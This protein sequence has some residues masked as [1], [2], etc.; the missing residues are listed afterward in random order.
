MAL[1]PEDVQAIGQL[2][3]SRMAQ[4]SEA[5]AKQLRDQD[6]R[7]R[8]FWSWVIWITVI[9]T[10]AS[11][12]WSYYWLK[13]K[14][15][16]LLASTASLER[17]L[18]QSRTDLAEARGEYASQL[19][20]DKQ[21]QKERAEAVSTSGYKSDQNQAQF[22]AGMLAKT[23]ALLNRSNEARSRAERKAKSGDTEPDDQSVNDLDQTI[24]QA[25]GLLM[26]LMLHETDPEH[27]GSAEKMAQGEHP[28]ATPI[29]QPPAAGQAKPPAAPS[30]QPA[31]APSPAQPATAS[32]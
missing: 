30:A 26:Q 31:R 23:F 4:H 27:Q 16:G 7:R 18:S 32:K 21:M 5:I 8:R 28:D 10:V 3:D 2:L 15:S 25:S 20:H 13:D 24:S 19:A 12:V 17:D 1:T 9:L 29:Q 11:S 14:V 22:D 6:R